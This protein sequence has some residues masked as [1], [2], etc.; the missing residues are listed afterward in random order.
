M[1]KLLPIGLVLA[2][3][4]TVRAESI[5]LAVITS[6]PTLLNLMVFLCAIGG[7]VITIKVLALTRGGQL[8]KSWY[9]F[10]SAFSVLI[11]GQITA[12]LGSLGVV[13]LP[14]FAMP[15]LLVMTAGLFVLG[16][17]EVKRVL[18]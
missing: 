8:D 1:K 7:L 18:G 10:I 14:S 15:L 4:S 5:N 17:F 16:M 9:M 6:A 3:S 11:L 2:L 12:V 13:A